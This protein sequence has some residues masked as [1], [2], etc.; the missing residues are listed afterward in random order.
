MKNTVDFKSAIQREKWLAGLLIGISVVAMKGIG[1]RTESLADALDEIFS[2]HYAVDVLYVAFMTTLIW[3]INRRSVLALGRRINWSVSPYRKLLVRTV[4]NVTGSGLIIYACTAIYFTFFGVQFSDTIFFHT[5][6]PL[7]LLITLLI[8][9]VYIGI[10]IGRQYQDTIAQPASAVDQS[11][12]EG[13]ARRVTT[14]D[15]REYIN[16]C[17]VNAGKSSVPVYTHEVAFFYKAG[18]ITFLKT[19]SG[20]E[21]T[22]EYTLEQLEQGL[23]PHVFFRANRQFIINQ[24]AVKKFDQAEHRKLDVHTNPATASPLVISQKKAVAFKKW[25]KEAEAS[26]LLKPIE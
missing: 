4:I 18:E 19:F 24:K 3:Y 23:D 13:E 5:D 20:R 9:M 14:P 2:W 1:F 7:A 12:E 10:L 25:M 8:N 22:V 11:I 26:T 15:S 21:Y 17:L 16:Y 6:L